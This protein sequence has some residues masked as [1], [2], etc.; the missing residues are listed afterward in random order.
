MHS[1]GG[2][3]TALTPPSLPTVSL[4]DL[5]N[6]Q[7]AQ[8]LRLHATSPT[9]T[10]HPRA[11]LHARMRPCAYVRT[12]A[13]THTALH[14]R[15]RTNLHARTNNL[16]TRTPTQAAITRR[17][18]TD[19]CSYATAVLDP[20]SPSRNVSRRIGY[21][22]AGSASSKVGGWLRAPETGVMLAWR[23]LLMWWRA[24]EERPWLAAFNC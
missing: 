6:C 21:F 15:A 2:G 10:N 3:I 12:H 13:R 19:F 4:V 16:N 8:R 20:E 18:F 24:R 5:T 14:Q 7:L 1:L 22:D 17:N 9:P 11:Y 23:S